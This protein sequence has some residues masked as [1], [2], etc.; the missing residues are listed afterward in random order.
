MKKYLF[1]A[2]IF[3]FAA[4]MASALDLKKAKN[5]NLADSAEMKQLNS[6]L[7]TV[8]NQFGPI[9]FVTGK[10]DLD[11]TKCK[12]TLDTLAD[13]VKKYPRFIV[14]VEGH[15]DNVGKKQANMALSQKR[16]ESVIKWLTGPG[17][18]KAAQLKAKGYGD[19]KP[20]ADNKTDEGR[21]KNRRVDFS[22]SKM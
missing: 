16:A 3:I 1:A 14:T 9:V 17:A 20:I 10:A 5:T 2:M 19:T 22:V 21:A 12:K 18:V 4:S 15:T 13:I 6:S 7:K 11:V 8:Q